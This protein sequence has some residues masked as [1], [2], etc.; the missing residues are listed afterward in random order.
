MSFQASTCSVHVHRRRDDG[1][2]AFL[3][4][5]GDQVAVAAGPTDGIPQ[6]SPQRR[7]NLRLPNRGGHAIRPGEGCRGPPRYRRTM[8]VSAQRVGTAPSTPG[9][10]LSFA[11]PCGTTLSNQTP[12]DA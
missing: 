10:G 6:H 11:A 2:P 7:Q 9:S 4:A 3:S 5:S 1:G 8:N 12:R